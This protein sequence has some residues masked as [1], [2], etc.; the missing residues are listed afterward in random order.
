MIRTAL[1]A[2]LFACQDIKDIGGGAGLD[3]PW[4]DVVYQCETPAHGDGV[5][6]FCFDD[7]ADELEQRLAAQGIEATCYPTPRHL[8]P[9]VYGCPDGTCNAFNGCYCP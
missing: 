5:Y 7:S 8:G 4:L 6:E 2:A 1:L 3:L 9:C